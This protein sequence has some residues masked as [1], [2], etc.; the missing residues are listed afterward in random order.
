MEQEEREREREEANKLTKN[1]TDLRNTRKNQNKY[2]ERGKERN[3]MCVI[4]GVY[5]V[6]VSTHNELV[7]IGGENL[8]KSEYHVWNRKRMREK[9]KKITNKKLSY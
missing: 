5:C 9:A 7:C 3:C 2:R 4:R 8:R 1:N 6:M